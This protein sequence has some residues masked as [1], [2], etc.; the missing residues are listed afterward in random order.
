MLFEE[1]FLCCGCNVCLNVC[2]TGAIHENISNKGFWKVEI[3]KDKCV[4]CGICEEI[5]PLYHGK[6]RKRDAVNIILPEAYAAK[7][8]QYSVR[9]SSQSGGMFTLLAKKCLKDGGAVYGVSMKG[10]DARYIR[11]TDDQDIHKL[12]GSKYVQANVGDVT[13]AVIKDIEQGLNIIFSGTPC[14]VA[15]IKNL[16][17]R[18]QLGISK[19]LFVDI[20]CHGT[21]S[22][23][24]LKKYLRHI[25]IKDA[26]RCQFNF[27][28]KVYYG[29]GGGH[30]CSYVMN[31]IKYYDRAY[32]DL[33]YSHTCLNEC[34]YE[35]PY[36]SLNRAGD[37]TIGDCWG[38]NKVKREFN[39]NIGASLVLV[40]NEKGKKAFDSI[41]EDIKKIQIDD[42]NSVMQ[43]NLQQ[44]TAKPDN[45][46]AFWKI[47]LKKGYEEAFNM[48]LNCDSHEIELIGET[49]EYKKCLQ[50][51][52]DSGIKKVFLYGLGVTML[53]FL[54]LLRQEGNIEAAGVTGWDIEEENDNI[55]N[56]P[57]IET[58]SIDRGE[59][60][61]ICTK[62]AEI[63]HIIR[64]RLSNSG[65]IESR[66]LVS[67]AD[68]C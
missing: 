46:A 17:L 18:Y 43:R 67:I 30:I 8:K 53:Q 36:A 34:C 59:C 10:D 5:C 42:I 32:V 64:E 2:P 65:I 62:K 49:P 12:Q 28:D 22:P 25:G 9:V 66:T 45:Y 15:G 44:P 29:W 61:V 14:V 63:S 31:E 55:W 35:C 68:F 19:I 23:A 26:D 39:D 57:L 52:K 11:I 4:N 40:N 33:F 51:L 50:Y 60:I 27:R 48:V 47:V 41:S 20:V 37:I 56:I 24:V 7:A 16:A 54:E 6:G 13:N 38:I 58:R 3:D 1:D 21:P